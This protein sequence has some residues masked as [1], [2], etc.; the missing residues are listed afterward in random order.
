[1]ACESTSGLLLVR[2][3]RTH[4]PGT[5]R[6]LATARGHGRGVRSNWRQ[7]REAWVHVLVLDQ[8]RLLAFQIT[9]VAVTPVSVMTSSLTASAAFGRRICRAMPVRVHCYDGSSLVQSSGNECT[10]RVPCLVP[11]PTYY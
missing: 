6:L 10:V 3:R 1:M 2:A 8:G 7:A 9:F 5:V 4:K 11:R